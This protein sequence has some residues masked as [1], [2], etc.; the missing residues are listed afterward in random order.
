MARIKVVLA[1]DHEILRRSLAMALSRDQ[2]F[3][4]LGEAGNGLELIDLCRTEPPDV[5]VVDIRM[6]VMD[7]IEAAKRIKA[8]WPQVKILILTTFDD[9]EYLR[10]LFSLGID[11]Y[12]LKN[13]DEIALGCAVKSVYIGFNTLDKGIVAKLSALMSG[14]RTRQDGLTEPESK[15]AR[16]IVAGLYNKDIAR[17]LDISYGYA[18][19]LVSEIY[20]KLG[21]ADRADMAEKLKS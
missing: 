17:E 7:G 11:G 14:G 5:A 9:D 4:V 20:H 1:E 21:A 6:P 12:L 3:E 15:V 8:E 2:D 13:E 19:N 18:R 10:E 16:L